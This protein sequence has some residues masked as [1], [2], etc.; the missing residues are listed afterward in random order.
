MVALHY[1]ITLQHY[2][3]SLTPRLQVA[4]AMSQRLV[5]KT[6][7]AKVIQQLETAAH[8]NFSVHFLAGHTAAGNSRV[9]AAGFA[10]LAHCSTLQ[11]F[12]SLSGRSGCRCIT[13][14]AAL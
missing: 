8:C 11:G 10:P 5:A 9:V 2:I 6:E 4:D 12:G 13:R 14:C 1:N 7:S 3:T